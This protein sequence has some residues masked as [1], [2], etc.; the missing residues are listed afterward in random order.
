MG[1]SGHEVAE[2]QCWVEG[3]PIKAFANID[4]QQAVRS[5][6][7]V[8]QGHC[9]VLR[10]SEEVDFAVP[11]HKDLHT[12]HCHTPQISGVRSDRPNKC[13]QSLPLN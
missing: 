6:Q 13:M 2:F 3:P 1:H 7:Q 8:T 5:E 11:E 9:G 12:C 10:D 4:W